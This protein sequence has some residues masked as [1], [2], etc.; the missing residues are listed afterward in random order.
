MT[1]EDKEFIESSVKSGKA[2]GFPNCCIKEFCKK[3]P[4]MMKASGLTND[5]KLRFKAAIVDGNF[6]GFVPCIEHA[7]QILSGAIK[8]HDLIDKSKRKVSNDFP[9]DWSLK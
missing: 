7:K 6:S 2:Y 8:I 3:T 5:D 1:Q 9:N 4:R